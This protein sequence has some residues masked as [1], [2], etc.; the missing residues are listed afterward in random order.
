[1]RAWHPSRRCSTMARTTSV[2]PIVRNQRREA[3]P[4]A[5]IPF[6][7]PRKA[8]AFCGSPWIGGRSRGFATLLPDPRLEPKLRGGSPAAPRFKPKLVPVRLLDPCFWPKPR[9]VH[10]SEHCCG[11]S[12]GNSPG[13]LRRPKPLYVPVGSPRPA[14]AMAVRLSRN[15]VPAEAGR[16]FRPRPRAGRSRSFVP[17][18]I[19]VKAEAVA[20]LL[21]SAVPAEADR[22]L[23]FWIPV[24]A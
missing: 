14:E 7:S 4:D 22:F 19:P 3:G 8:E 24:K 18:R 13:V 5:S 23:R 12:P 16:L 1:V 10:R 2:P 20:V 15:S 17:V 9:A 11:R 6:G 21:R